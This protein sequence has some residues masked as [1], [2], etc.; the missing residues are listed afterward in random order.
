MIA[1]YHCI[2]CVD[3]LAGVMHTFKTYYMGCQC[4]IQCVFDFGGLRA[5]NDRCM[6]YAFYTFVSYYTSNYQSDS[7]VDFYR[8]GGPPKMRSAFFF[9]TP[10]TSKFLSFGRLRNC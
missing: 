9:G 1:V 5:R 2:D 10:G 3:S 8:R 4:T 7:R 6:S